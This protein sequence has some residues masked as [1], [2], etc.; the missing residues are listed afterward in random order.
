MAA[1]FAL[2]GA[3]QAKGMQASISAGACALNL[4]SIL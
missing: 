4:F 2:A 3:P 1:I